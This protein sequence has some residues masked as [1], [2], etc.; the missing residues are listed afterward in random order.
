MAR[1]LNQAHDRK[2]TQVG[3]FNNSL[4]TLFKLVIT[5]LS[6]EQFCVSTLLNN[7]PVVHHYYL[8]ETRESAKSMGDH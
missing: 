2:L 3:S 4:Q 7:L 8:L 6:G 5:P 1:K